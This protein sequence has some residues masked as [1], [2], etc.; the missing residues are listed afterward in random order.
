VGKALLAT[1]FKK[2]P[3]TF[4]GTMVEAVQGAI[5]TQKVHEVSGRLQAIVADIRRCLDEER[6]ALFQSLRTKVEELIGRKRDVQ[7]LLGPYPELR[8]EEP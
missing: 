4:C 6:P 1:V 7:R 8:G 3:D 2:A 5:R